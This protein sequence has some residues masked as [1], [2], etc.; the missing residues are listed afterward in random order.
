M[1]LGTLKGLSSA[2]LLLHS[3]Q[4]P[5]ILPLRFTFCHKALI[6]V[7][8]ERDRGISWDGI[9]N[10]SVEMK[11]YRAEE[12]VAKGEQALFLPTPLL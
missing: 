9:T 4:I 12:L 8:R 6:T 5:E 1:M 10:N 11:N 2:G 3:L 7:E